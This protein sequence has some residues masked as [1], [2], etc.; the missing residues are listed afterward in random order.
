MIF[1]CASRF[2]SRCCPLGAMALTVALA[3]CSS[4]SADGT[5]QP[6][7]RNILFLAID[8]FGVDQLTSYGYGGKFP[9]KTPNLNAI[10]KAGLLFRSAWSMPTCTP[11][12]ATFFTGRYPSAT[13][14]L[15]AV[16]SSDLANSEIS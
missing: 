12:R 16:V 14:V 7:R 2:H 8:D 9:A 3:G 11:T 15:N 4:G 5:P 6:S 10:A 1:P 13:N